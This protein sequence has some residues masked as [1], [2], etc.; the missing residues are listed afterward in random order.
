MTYNLNPV[1]RWRLCHRTYVL[2]RQFG[3]GRAFSAAIAISMLLFGRAPRHRI[4]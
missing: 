4:R 3:R 1:V 2:T